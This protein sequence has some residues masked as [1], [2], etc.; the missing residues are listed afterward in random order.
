MIKKLE[1]LLEVRNYGEIRILLKDENEVD[2]ASILEEFPQKDLIIV[3]RLL[4]K[5]KAAE[6]FSYLPVD[7]QKQL[8][9][10]LSNRE[11]ANIIDD[12]YTDDAVDI[13][14]EMP[15]NVVKKILSLAS[16]ETRK[17]I[18]LLLKYPTD[19]AGSIMTTEFVDLFAE[20]TVEK[21]IQRVKALG[22]DSETINVCYV[23]NDKRHLVGYVSLRT[24]LLSEPDDLIGDLMTENIKMAHTND[25][26]EKIAQM[27]QKYDFYSIAVVD[28]EDRLVGIVTVD[29]VM[30][31]MQEETTEDIEKMAAIMPTDKPYL[32]TSIF[33]TYKKRI[34][35]LLL[36]M[37]S[38]SITGKI[39]SGFEDALSS[40]VVLTAFIPMLMDTG[41]NAGSQASVSIIRS[42]SLGE[43][44][45]RDVPK[46]VCKEFGVSLLIGI[47]LSIANFFKIMLIDH[48]TPLVALVICVT[49]FATIVIAKMVGCL[50]P[51]FAKKLGFDPAIMASPFITTIVDALS[52]MVYFNIATMLLHIG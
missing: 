40:Y 25:D 38:A 34:P 23:I 5:D 21:A 31:I 36:L 29:D 43:I 49:I 41:G 3:F 32:K 47:T 27:F 28:N 4:P 26:Q 18:N 48:V 9:E 15:A 51:M 6:V 42:I 24:L 14:E 20:L 8:V 12:L 44:E 19:S 33:E 13:I 1:D 22:I 46:I 16:P 10:T 39:I 52:L 35:W 45:F 37:I 7:I 50:L 11:V 17:D 30:D 2:I